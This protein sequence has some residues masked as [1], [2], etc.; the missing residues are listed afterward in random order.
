MMSVPEQSPSEIADL[1]ARAE[2]V[3]AANPA[4]V[5]NFEWT[6]RRYWVKREERLSLRMRLQKG[7]PRR[8]FAAERRGLHELTALGAPVLPILAEGPHYLVTPD[9]G[10]A[11]HTLLRDSAFD[12]NERLAA[13]EA[14]GR[15]LAEFHRRGVS[16]GRP[17]IRDICWDGKAARFIDVERY[18]DKRNNAAGHAQDLV[19]L[20]FSAFAEARGPCTEIAALEAA[21]RAADPGGIWAGAERLCRRLRW[22]GPLSW[23]ARRFLRSREFRAIPP[24]L[25]MFGAA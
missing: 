8:A 20:M 1:A 13:F 22:L 19:I 21:Y 17:S 12:P 18:A 23:P 2:A 15:G 3:L 6:G 16:H 14:A 9:G 24:T 5:Q 11:L 7:D 25:S 10:R 4:R